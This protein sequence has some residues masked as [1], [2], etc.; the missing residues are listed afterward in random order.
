MPATPTG[1]CPGVAA[2]A[3]TSGT[4]ARTRSR[5][6]RTSGG[7]RRGPRRRSARRDAAASPA[8][9]RGQHHRRVYGD[10]PT[11]ELRVPYSE[12]ESTLRSRRVAD[13]DRPIDA[14]LAC[15]LREIGG[16]LIR[17]VAP[18]GRTREP[19]TAQVRCDN[20]EVVLE[21]GEL[22]VPVTRGRGGSRL[23]DHLQPTTASIQ[24]S[25]PVAT[26]GAA[27]RPSH[28]SMSIGESAA[29]HR[30]IA[31]TPTWWPPV[32]TTRGPQTH[33]AR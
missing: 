31:G 22:Q 2:R 19:V 25:A 9:R 7:T 32:A 24:R 11:H 33:G 23:V 3:A 27:L 1:P 21:R 28:V 5:T 16:V 30:V 26:D 8:E 6:R 15:Q 10:N 14:E 12:R 13:N 17:G 18:V 4:P 29:G 20:S